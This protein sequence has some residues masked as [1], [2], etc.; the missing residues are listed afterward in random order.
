MH[1]QAITPLDVFKTYSDV[2]M[3]ATWK[4]KGQEIDLSSTAVL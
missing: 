1:A 2:E 4:G 3:D